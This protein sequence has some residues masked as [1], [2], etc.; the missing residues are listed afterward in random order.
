MPNKYKCSGCNLSFAHAA[1]L[2]DHLISDHGWESEAAW[3]RC[4]S[5]LYPEEWEMDSE[6]I[7]RHSKAADVK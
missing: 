4:Q 3:V 7:L 2:H 5:L 6:G 1:Q